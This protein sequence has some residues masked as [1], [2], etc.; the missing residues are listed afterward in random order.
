MKGAKDGIAKNNKWGDP[1]AVTKAINGGK[2]HLK[3]RTNAFAF[4]RKKYKV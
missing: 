1:V 2:M 3:D 4:Y